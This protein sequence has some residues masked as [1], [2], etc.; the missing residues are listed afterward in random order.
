MRSK[1][2]R[3]GS[4]RGIGIRAL[5]FVV[6]ACATFICAAPTRAAISSAGD[7]APSP[8]SGGG[9]VAGPFH[10]GNVDVGTMN[11]TNGTALT[12]TNN[13]FI[14]ETVTGLGIVTMNGFGSDW[15]LTT[16][17]RIS[18]SLLTARAH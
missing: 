13:A 9:A 12:N 7:V 11:I 1:L 5:A 6:A 10:I 14:G 2:A 18:P 8:P 16:P 4:V 17:V 15:T 3:S